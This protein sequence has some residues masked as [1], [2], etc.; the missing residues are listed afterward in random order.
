[1]NFKGIFPMAKI[2]KIIV[3]VVLGM[4]VILFFGCDFFGDQKEEFFLIVNW[5]EEHGQVFIQPH[6]GKYEKGTEVNLLASPEEGWKFSH[7]EGDVEGTDPEIMIVMD[8]N[9]EITAI[10]SPI[11]F[12]LGVEIIGKGK[13]EKEPVTD[14]QDSYEFGTKIKLTA[15][16]DPNQKFSH[17]EGDALGTEE[18][19]EIIMDSDKNLTAYFTGPEAWASGTISIE[20]N[21]PKSV[22]EEGLASS[23]TTP[24]PERKDV[25]GMDY[26]QYKPGEMII[27]FY[28][29][30]VQAEKN[31]VF[32]A[33]NLEVIDQTK[34][35]NSYLVKTPG[36]FIDAEIRMA[37]QMPG[38][39]YAGPNYLATACVTYPNDQLFGDQ[40]HYPQ[41]RLPQAWTSTT[42]SSNIRIA[43]LDTGV[44]VSHPDLGDNVDVASGYN[45]II[46]NS[47][48]ND[49]HGHGTHVAG[50]IGANTNNVEGVA[51]VMW[52]CTIIPVKVLDDEGNGYYW[53]IE[54]GILYAAGL[55]EPYLSNRAH[56]INMSLGGLSYCPLLEEAVQKAANAGVIMVAASG[57]DDGGA[58]RYPAGYQETIAVG[59]VKY[60]YQDEP[61]R[62]YYSN[63]GPLL[64]VVA[65]G[66][67]GSG[68]VLS[69]YFSPSGNKNYNYAYYQG[70][71]MATPHV[72]GVIG[73]MLTRGIGPNEVREILHRTS[74]DLGEEG[75]DEE[76]GHGLVNAYWAVH[77]V[78]KIKILVGNR[79]GEIINSV[80]E[81]VVDLKRQYYELEGIPGGEYRVYGWIDIKGNGVIEPGDYL[82]ESHLIDFNETNIL[83][84][85]LVLTEVE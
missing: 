69:T 26:G 34:I 36:Q 54:K 5:V 9:K 29:V 31:S 18:E 41:I 10:F 58:L 74:I 12:S 47:D 1:M 61:E 25:K 45:F 37:E 49:F 46:N 24:A 57:N 73:L 79:D 14:L 80:F 27:K 39:A 3:F 60:N 50:T 85:D 81:K 6:Q 71:S 52:D 48:T 67:D 38:V 55:E 83:E 77:D 4:V 16:P 20:H 43:V 11:E 8:R 78:Q 22:V 63:Y 59:A 35:L 53:Q 15:I 76:Y 82:A 40:W 64:D 68:G 7:W 66:G 19:I 62:A 23:K 28:P 42:G 17:W 70:T 72:A 75:F 21:W 84:I 2:K 32:Q 44:D 13:V 33:L 65:P 56:I 30:T 51:G